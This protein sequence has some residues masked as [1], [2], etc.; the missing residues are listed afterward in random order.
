MAKILVVDD[1]ESLREMLCLSLRRAGFD[2]IEASDGNQ[3]TKLIK[4]ESVDL[5]ITDIIMPDKEGIQ[6]IIELRETKPEI[7]IIAMS[8]GGVV[9]SELYLDMA[10]R[11][12]ADRII[13]KPVFRDDLLKMIRE[14]LGGR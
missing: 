14:L 3:A 5:V 1:D 6:L 13:A 8:G 4:R 12:G 9:L 11:L 7:K 2:V 10:K